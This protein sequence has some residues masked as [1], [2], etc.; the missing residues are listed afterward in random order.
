MSFT[1]VKGD[2]TAS[3]GFSADYMVGA[4]I[5]NVSGIKS[6][7]GSKAN[8]N[9]HIN[10]VSGGL[11]LMPQSTTGNV[12]FVRVNSLK[13]F[14]AM[15]GVAGTYGKMFGEELI[16]TITIVGCMYKGK[17]TKAIDATIIMA[18]IYSPYQKYYTESLFKA[19]PIVIP[20]INLNYRITKTFGFGLTGGGTYIAGQDIIN[21]Q[22]L[23]GAKLKL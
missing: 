13:N 18:G 22:I 3:I 21:Y 15:Y 2:G 19:R 14:T 4:R 16:S 11:G 7:I 17:L 9:K 10:V 23:M 5:G 20:F 1:R 8:G 6:W 12:L